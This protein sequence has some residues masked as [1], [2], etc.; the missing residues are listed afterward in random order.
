MPLRPKAAE[1]LLRIHV[2]HVARLGTGLLACYRC[3]TAACTAAGAADVPLSAANAG[4][5]VLCGLQSSGWGVQGG[6]RVAR[7]MNDMSRCIG[8]ETVQR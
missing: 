6:L 8:Q 4:I 3:Y 1:Q 2:W 5:A 7:H